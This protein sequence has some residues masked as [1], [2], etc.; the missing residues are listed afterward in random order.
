MSVTGF[1]LE[2]KQN[3]VKHSD[4]SEDKVIKMM[5]QYQQEK[6]LTET[7]IFVSFKYRQESRKRLATQ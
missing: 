7:I 6:T 3:L 1:C 4:L 2:T 5:F